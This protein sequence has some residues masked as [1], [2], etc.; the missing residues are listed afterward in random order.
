MPTASVPSHLAIIMDGNRRWAYQRNKSTKDGHESG[1]RIIDGICRRAHERGVEWM[2]LF[3]FSTENWK[4]SALELKGIMAVLR[5]YLKHELNSLTENNI[6]L[7]V[8]GDLTGFSSDLVDLLDHATRITAHNTGLN[9]TVALGFGGQADLVSAARNIAAQVQ[10]GTLSADKITA[11]V[12]KA[13]LSTADLPPV[14]MMLRTGN[15]KRISNFL[16]WDMA[17]AEM[18]FS[19]SLWPDFTVAMLDEFLDEY[20]TRTRRFGGDA[21]KGE[22]HQDN[23]SVDAATSTG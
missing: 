9:L 17:Y 8:V 6:R 23:Q 2:T 3:A 12:L 5:H 19:P 18:F 7:R 10:D 16:L 13:N 11:D 22:G 15:E 1:S 21:V 4:R 20:A 14:D